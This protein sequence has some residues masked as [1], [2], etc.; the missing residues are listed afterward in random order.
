MEVNMDTTFYKGVKIGE[1]TLE[2]FVQGVMKIL[3]SSMFGSTLPTYGQE[4]QIFFK[5]M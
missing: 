1:L 3:P 4:G 2:Q 5:K